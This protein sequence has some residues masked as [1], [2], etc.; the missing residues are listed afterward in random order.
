MLRG[1]IADPEFK[2]HFTGHETFPLRYG[3]LKKVVDALSSEDDR[4]RES[5]FNPDFAMSH[6]GVGKNMVM[7]MRHWALAAGV[8]ETK[9]RNQ[10]QVSDFG[11]RLLSDDGFDP[12]LEYP[13][14]LWLLH[15]KLAGTPDRTTTWYW[16]F[17][18]YA[19]PQL[20]REALMADIGRLARERGWTRVAKNTVRRDIDCFFRTY[21]FSKSK[22]GAVTED[23]LECPL[24]ELGLVAPTLTKGVYTFNRGPKDDLPGSVVAYALAEFWR[25]FTSAQTITVESLTHEP[26]SPGRVFKLDEQSMVEHLANIHAASDGAFRWT[27]T[28][29]LKQVIRTREDVDPLML[30]ELIYR[31]Q[32]SEMAA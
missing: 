21:A 15:W 16:A 3:W 13:A 7:A 30:L 11:R 8:I 24:A 5:T 23:S 12:Y 18:H 1:P 6:F 14:S 4:A 19:A 28:A 31:P 9:D 25:R 20:D 32:A 27:E 2:G 17:N 10:Y 22:H 26:G 29:G